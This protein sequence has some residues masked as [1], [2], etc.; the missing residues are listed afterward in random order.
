[1]REITADPELYREPDENKKEHAGS[2]KILGITG[3]GLAVLIGALAV[4]ICRSVIWV[5]TTWNDLTMEEIVFHL[6][7]PMEGTNSGM[8][9]DYLLFSAVPALLT[10]AALVLCFWLLRKRKK[11]RRAYSILL[12]CLGLFVIISSVAYIWNALEVSAY[13]ENQSTYS[14]FIDDNYVD[15]ASVPITFPEEKRNLIYIYLESM[16]TTFADKKSGGAFDENVI[17]ELTQLSMENEN[18]SGHTDLNGGYSLTGTTWTMGA[19][20]GQTSGLP[21]LISVDKNSMNTQESFFPGITTLGDILEDAGYRQEL[22]I[23]SEAVFGGRELYFQQHGNYEIYDYEYS[24]THGEIPEDYR[25][26]WG[27]ED[28]KLF[29]NAK[30]R[31]TELAESGQPF[32]LT[33]LTVD[34]HFEDGYVCSLCPDTYEGDPYSNVMACSSRQVAEF[35]EWIQQQPFYENTTIVISGDHPTMD[36]D[37]CDGIAEDYGRRV[38]TAYINAPVSPESDV[39]R[40]YSTF[41]AFP[42]TLASLGCNIPGNRLGLGVNLFSSEPTLVER[43]GT[44]EANAG[45]AQKSELMDRLNSD[46][47]KAEVSA[48]SYN[49]EQQAL[50][51]TVS[52]VHWNQTVTGAGCE[53]WLGEEKQSSHTYR[54]ESREDSTY[55]LEIPLSDFENKM[56]TY[57]ISVYLEL[58]DGSSVRIGDDRIEVT[59]DESREPSASVTAAPYDFLSGKLTLQITNLQGCGEF[60]GIR[61]AVWSDADRSDL[62]WYDAVENGA[63]SYQAE[64]YGE[65]FNF[66]HAAY[67]IHVYAVDNT[68]K[69]TMIGGC[70]AEM[71]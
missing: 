18:F 38:Y 35:V 6:K 37:Y 47:N 21:L 64:I 22:V 53:V 65:D 30:K 60:S 43:C 56:G 15:P 54:G 51:L 13:V 39:Y 66:R 69:E 61:C 10:A 25:V 42:T 20:F 28:E 46:I 33:M 1:M 44:A 36:A 14:S 5:L 29:A 59:A 9:E 63:G 40:E 41:D 48:V 8:I 71:N 31:L 4:F 16:E 67:T 70:H 23:G 34:T 50:T 3:K 11:I 19:M 49:Q 7:M 57:S 68:G 2:R 12:P 27:Y 58:E 45:L 24:R 62:Q 55:Y 52:G 17:P 26:W 32:N